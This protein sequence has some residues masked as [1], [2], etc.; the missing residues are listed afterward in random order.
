[1]TT[2][3][4][5]Q[6]T[7]ADLAGLVRES[8]IDATTVEQFGLYR[9]TS[10]EGAALVGRTDHEDYSGIVFPTFFPGT[11]SPREYFIR[12]DHPPLEQSSNG[13][14]KASRKYLA[15][16]GRGN[17][18]LFGPSESL[19]VL[20]D[21]TLPVVIVE[22]LKKQA[23]AWRLSRLEGPPPFLACG[24]S[25]VW[26]FRGTIARTL[27]P[28]GTRVA[29]KGVIPDLDRMTWTDRDVFILYDSDSECNPS[30]S[31]A[32][33]SLSNELRTRGARVIVMVL[34]SLDGL[35]KTG[36][37]DL[38]AQWGPERVL[39]WLHDAQMGAASA[40]DP[41]PISLDALRVPPFPTN[42]IPTNWLRDMVDATADATET[43]VELPLLLGLAVTAT[44][45][46]KKYVVEPTPDYYEP[47]NIWAIVLLDSGNRKSAVLKEIT[48][49]LLDFE[50]QHAAGIA[51]DI[52]RAESARQLAED[53]IKHLRQKA[54]RA[55]GV[56]LDA[57]RHELFQ[58]ESALP[59]VPKGLRLWCQDITPEKLGALMADH[60]E[61]MA[62]LSDEG[63][64]FE[65]IGGRYSQ[66]IPNLDLFLKAHSGS[67]YRVDRG[68]RPP[69]FMDSPALTLALSPQPAVLKGLTKIPDFR[70][71][72]LLAR[73]L[74]ALP[75]SLLGSRLL[76][77]RPI[78]ATVREAYHTAI[79]TLLQLFPR[80]DGTPHRLRL[81]E[82][83]HREW[84]AFQRHVEDELRDGGMFEHIRDWAGKLP[85]SVARLAGI[86]HCADHA[87]GAPHTHPIDLRTMEAALALG[88]LLE[89]HAL[90]VFSVMAVDSN[91][92]AA[93]KIWSWVLR[94]R[95][96]T[97]SKRD[98][99]HALQGAFQTM[100]GIQPA[101]EILLE[102][103]YLFPFQLKKPVGRPSPGYRVNTQLAKEWT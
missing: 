80:A 73:P 89:R 52:L 97:F 60:G 3:T 15:P 69:V 19:D 81:S 22:G 58:A 86:L 90:A 75:H 100:V 23:A 47:L 42:V 85:G 59:E 38:L 6:L 25:G 18:L 98:C 2:A 74:Y 99:F 17:R 40:E 10:A 34:P 94:E 43:P 5:G 65:N 91:L 46:Q 37:D 63:G 44:A 95:H 4:K 28:D 1:M 92:D 72:G 32:R 30:V 12:R 26:N 57:L 16:P 8:W 87:D 62:V 66:G 24:I 53:R 14:L 56:D 33:E 13:T 41:E 96:T 51:Q 84:K 36:V 79:H 35:R 68:S 70:G 103:G 39:S 82:E 11:D 93:K 76:D 88:G 7:D 77:P 31:A 20:T 64:I 9:V 45:V 21:T 101:F 83:A 49:P 29:I 102:R 67:S 54:A 71:K 61:K 78:P 50:R 48:A 27:G 55:D